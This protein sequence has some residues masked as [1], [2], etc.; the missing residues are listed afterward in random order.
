[1]RAAS[2]WALAI[3]AGLVLC[4]TLFLSTPPPAPPQRASPPP[5]PPPPVSIRLIDASAFPLQRALTPAELLRLGSLTHDYTAVN[6]GAL[7]GGFADG[8]PVNALWFDAA[9]AA[10]AAGWRRPAPSGAA[11]VAMEGVPA[12]CEQLGRAVAAARLS[13]VRVACEFAVPATI[14]ARLRALNVSRDFDFLKV[15]IDSVDCPVVD[16]I[17]AEFRPRY[18]HMETN[19]E[20]PPPIVFALEYSPALTQGW[21][22]RSLSFKGFYGCSMARVAEIAAAHG[23][24]IVQAH[25]ID[26]DLVRTDLLAADAVDAFRAPGAVRALWER[27]VRPYCYGHTGHM[28]MPQGCG[29]LMGVSNDEAVRRLWAH[30]LNNVPAATMAQVPF[31]LYA[32]DEGGP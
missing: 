22:W 4:A 10:N 9:A 13:H 15:D 19:Y 32:M 3:V 30:L 16:A 23:Y 7:D 6:I 8:D 25:N 5:P 12:Q 14:A 18:V 20:V 17:L 24:A 26:V 11:S 1:M 2:A 31:R 21:F 29:H 27:G 28:G